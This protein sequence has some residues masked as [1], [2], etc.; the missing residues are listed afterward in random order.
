[1]EKD[2]IIMTEAIASRSTR[3]DLWLTLTVGAVAA[4]YVLGSLIVRLVEILGGGDIAVPVR[5]APADLSIGSSS[6]ATIS[7]DE[8]VVRVSELPAATFASV[9]LAAILP[10]VASLIV[11]GCSIAVFRRVLN[12]NP[13]AP[14]TAKLVTI[15][16]F[17]ILGGWIA[18]G[19]FDTMAS[20]GALA[21]V[22]PESDTMTA[23]HVSWLPFLAAMA[24]AALAVLIRSGEKMRADTEG[25]V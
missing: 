4:V 7:V 19:L 6:T 13:F 11:I 2:L 5:F 18:S 10:A 14:G 9:L 25:L 3:N 20:N 22:A 15:S 1:M 17:A 8:G 23:L 24:V 21:V 12:G 16:S